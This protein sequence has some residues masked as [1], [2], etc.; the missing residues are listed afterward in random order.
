M[1]A[2]TEQLREEMRALANLRVAFDKVDAHLKVEQA[3][4]REEINHVYEVHEVTKKALRATEGS[5]RQIQEENPTFVA[6]GVSV[7]MATEIVYNVE[8]ALEYAIEH[9]LA[10]C[11]KLDDRAFKKLAQAMDIDCVTVSKAAKAKIAS[12]LSMYVKGNEHDA[13]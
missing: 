11:L 5:V 13:E 1:T 12:D 10:K 9:K 8:L 6:D 2:T 7:M 4:Q 3:R